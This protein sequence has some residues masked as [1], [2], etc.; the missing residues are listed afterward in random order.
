MIPAQEDKHRRGTSPVEVLIV[1]AIVGLLILMAMMA[2]P[3]GRENARL[4]S[5][6][7]NLMQIG[8]AMAWY[9]SSVGHLP[10]IPPAGQDRPGPLP[11]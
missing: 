5:C 7:G 10:A 2:L 6:N 11:T 3:R 4:A 1:V 9:D 8:K